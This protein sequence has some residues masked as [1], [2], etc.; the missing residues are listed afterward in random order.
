M[1][2]AVSSDRTLTDL[3]SD[4]SPERVGLGFWQKV[5]VDD[6]LS[7]TST[8]T[9]VGPLDFVPVPVNRVKKKGS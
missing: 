6:T 7:G 3:L 5:G 1:V 9:V 8:R 2:R 4:E